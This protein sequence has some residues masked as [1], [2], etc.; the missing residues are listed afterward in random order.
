MS[1]VYISSREVVDR[2][3]LHTQ[4][5][6]ERG[7]LLKDHMRERVVSKMTDSWYDILV[8]TSSVAACS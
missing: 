1:H 2:E 4:T 7:N 6:M 3:T 8:S 5:E